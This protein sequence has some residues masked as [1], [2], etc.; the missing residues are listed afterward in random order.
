MGWKIGTTC[1]PLRTITSKRGGPVSWEDWGSDPHQGLVTP[2]YDL[3]NPWGT[4]LSGGVSLEM[5]MRVS[6]RRLSPLFVGDTLGG[7]QG[8]RWLGPDG[9]LL[10]MLRDYS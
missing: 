6:H 5:T 9:Q 1:L 8:S 2:S 7:A 10:V 3:P 4:D